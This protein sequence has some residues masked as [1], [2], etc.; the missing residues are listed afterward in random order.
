MLATVEQKCACACTRPSCRERRSR[1]RSDVVCKG[2]GGPPRGVVS[3]GVA[4]E[5][6]EKE[7]RQE[8][9]REKEVVR[10]HLS[11][12]PPSVISGAAEPEP[13]PSSLLFCQCA[14]KAVCVQSGDC[15]DPH[16]LA[17]VKLKT[18]GL[19]TRSMHPRTAG[20]AEAVAQF[21]STAPCN[22]SIRVVIP[23]SR[24]PF[25]FPAHFE[26]SPSSRQEF[27]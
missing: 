8:G 20:N 4:D 1:W 26:D 13:E 5:A 17:P 12:M 27:P 22:E 15:N 2:G 16:G 3:M 14:H 21:R 10:G 9:E 18:G 25:S 19:G 11:G 6:D 24:Y 7:K 23:V